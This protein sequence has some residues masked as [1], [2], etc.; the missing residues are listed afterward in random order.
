[1]LAAG[2]RTVGGL[3]DQ[4]KDATNILGTWSHV[5][6]GNRFLEFKC[7]Y[8]GL[9]LDQRAGGVDG[10]HAGVRFPGPDDRRAVQLPAD[11]DQNNWTG[12]ADFPSWHKDKHDIKIG[13]EYL[14]V[15]DGGP[16][17]I[18]RAGFF[19]SQRAGQPGGGR[20]PATRSTR[21]RGTWRR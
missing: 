3:G 10:R 2:G 1:M 18:Q 4:T 16:W 17:F 21:R 20:L 8:N 15:H 6:G 13:G 11:A 12:R 19:T 9:R 5:F 7:G 14:H